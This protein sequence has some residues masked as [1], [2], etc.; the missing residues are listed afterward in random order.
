[1][2]SRKSAAGTGTECA[3][4]KGKNSTSEGDSQA[5]PPPG[6]RHAPAKRCAATREFSPH[7]CLARR[8]PL[9]PPGCRG[10]TGG[11]ERSSDE[12]KVTPLIRGEA[13]IRTRQPGSPSL[14][15]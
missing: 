8:T 12:P 9:S 4:G 14:E 6:A 11:S 1:M 5:Q 7:R 3:K 10:G 13:G 2:H 15:L